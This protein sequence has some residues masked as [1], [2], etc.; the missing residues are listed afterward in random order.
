[1]HDILTAPLPYMYLEAVRH[2]GCCGRRFTQRY[3][4]SDTHTP[5]FFDKLSATFDEAVKLHRSSCRHF[6]PADG[7]T[8]VALPLE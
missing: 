4:A 5:D 1:M 7:P 8:T 3:L 6:D 2:A